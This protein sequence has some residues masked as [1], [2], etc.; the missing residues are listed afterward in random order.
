[1]LMDGH[2]DRQYFRKILNSLELLVAAGSS[3]RSETSNTWL[4]MW[5]K[6]INKLGLSW[7]KLSIAGVE[8]C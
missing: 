6:L 2:M 1:M 3:C 4:V 7:A 8:L 5:D